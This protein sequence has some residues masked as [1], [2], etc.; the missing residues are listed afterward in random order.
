MQDLSNY[1]K[2]YDKSELLESA[3][4]EDPINNGWFHEIK[5]SWWNGRS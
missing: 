2:S 3:I 4:P 5:G 1:R